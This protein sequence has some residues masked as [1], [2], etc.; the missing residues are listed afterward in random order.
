MNDAAQRHRRRHVDVNTFA[1]CHVAPAVSMPTKITV[2]VTLFVLF[3]DSHLCAQST[4]IIYFF[5]VL[6]LW[7]LHTAL[8]SHLHLQWRYQ[9]FADSATELSDLQST[10]NTKAAFT[11]MLDSIHFVCLYVTA[12]RSFPIQGLAW[13]S[14]W[15]HTKA[16][17]DVQWSW[18]LHKYLGPTH[19]H[20]NV[21]TVFRQLPWTY[22][23]PNCEPVF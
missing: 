23:I 7:T 21:R 6:C 20:T 18:R 17:F 11:D 14:F 22:T 3:F 12:C 4:Q 2:N 13:W 9:S 10:K 1:F 8:Q 16:F 15:C 19:I 5:V